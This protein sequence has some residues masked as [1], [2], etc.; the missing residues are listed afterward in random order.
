MP[1]KQVV[2]IG[3]R[4]CWD[5][6]SVHVTLD[7]LFGHHSQIQVICP[8][9]PGAS[10]LGKT[11]A[12]KR[13]HRIKGF[14]TNWFDLEAE[15]A[16]IK[17]LRDGRTYNASA[18]ADRNRELLT[19]A[20]ETPDC[21]LV[22]FWD[23]KAKDTRALAETAKTMGIK[24]HVVLVNPSVR[25]HDPFFDADFETSVCMLEARWARGDTEQEYED[26][27]QRKSDRV[28]VE[29]REQDSPGRAEQGILEAATG[30]LNG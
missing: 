3:S 25:V 9:T 12:I 10:V 26:G 5:C 24:V 30:A 28:S 1:E 23:G 22:S 21:E 6:K 14:P 18:A 16:V 17:K 4:H 7:T 27:K 2:V 19:Y 20:R 15:G 13:G 8:D 11:W 29:V